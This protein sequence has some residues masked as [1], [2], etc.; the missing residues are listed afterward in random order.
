LADDTLYWLCHHFMDH[1]PQP[2]AKK[3]RIM[4]AWQTCYIMSRGGNYSRTDEDFV[5]FPI[6]DDREH[7]RAYCGNHWTGLAVD[8]QHK[9]CCHFNSAPEFTKNNQN[10]RQLASALGIE[11]RECPGPRQENGYDCGMFTCIIFRELANDFLSAYRSGRQWCLPR[12]IPNLSHI[13]QEYVSGIRRHMYNL[14]M[15]NCRGW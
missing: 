4:T 13:S 5:F 15:P 11:Y 10:A 9:V 8:L 1:M 12:D 14:L 7:L 6:N 3:V 2:E